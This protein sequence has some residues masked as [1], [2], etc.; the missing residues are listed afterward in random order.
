MQRHT[1]LK[2]GKPLSR[3]SA[4]GAEGETRQQRATAD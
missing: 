2:P 3:R 1:P 4:M